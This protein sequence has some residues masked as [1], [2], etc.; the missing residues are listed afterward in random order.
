VINRKQPKNKLT[1][2][3]DTL[4]LK[5]EVNQSN[6]RPEMNWYGCV[7]DLFNCSRN[8][9]GWFGLK[10]ESSKLTSTLIIREQEFQNMS[11]R[12]IARNKLGEDSSTW[13]VFDK[14]TLFFQYMIIL[15]FMV[16]AEFH[17]I[18]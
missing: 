1:K 16:H 17:H 2:F 8:S 12:C 7:D 3:H 14:S 5:C 6:P 9:L 13:N 10:K 4:E 15:H 11:Y 18:S